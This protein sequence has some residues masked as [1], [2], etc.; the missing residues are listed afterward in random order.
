M[1]QI[2]LVA[3]LRKVF[4]RDVV[5]LRREL[6]LYPDEASVW[7]AVAGLPN[8]GGNLVLHL[9]G[10]LRWFIGAQLGGTGYVRDRDAE[11]AARD[12]PRE[13]LVSGIEATRLELDV[14]LARLPADRLATLYP[15][16][17]GGRS[18]PTGLFLLHLAVHLGYHLGQLDYHRRAATGLSA[19]AGA[20]SIPALLE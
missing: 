13:A 16:P 3:D 8:A 2:D 1:A 10:N 18:V 5:T 20:V 15:L 19:G 7:K 6:E 14:T 12:V 4:L 11:F 17:V 9:C